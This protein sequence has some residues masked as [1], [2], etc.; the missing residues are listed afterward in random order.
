MEQKILFFD[1]DNTLY[2]HKNNCVPASTIDAI[3]KLKD[4]GHIVAIATG[5]GPIYISEMC[6]ELEIDTYVG[7]NGNYVVL[8][9]ELISIT[10]LS[11]KNVRSI[12][13]Y[14]LENDLKLVY[15]SVDGYYTMH[16]NDKSIVKYYQEFN[17]YYPNIID[18]VSDFKHYTQLTI[19]ANEEQEKAL[20]KQFK[21]FD[22]IRVNDYGLNILEK[23]G[24]KEKG[25]QKIM[26]VLHFERNNIICFG[27]GL[28]DI[29]MF[30]FAGTSVAMNNGH[31]LLKQIATYIT[32]DVDKDGIYNACIKL[33]LIDK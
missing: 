28:N 8:E 18:E 12:H 4:N 22:F 26:D 19:M 16:A 7:F 20:R 33:G 3:N 32:N 6:G 21:Q 9:D 10:Y 17:T 31:T 2:D 25:I 14:C 29:S 30:Q 13:D 23:G 5:R 24:Q 27:D 1:I 15:T 11:E